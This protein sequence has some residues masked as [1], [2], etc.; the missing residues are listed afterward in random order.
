[1]NVKIGRRQ[2]EA[3]CYLFLGTVF[4]AIG[5]TLKA[6]EYNEKALAIATEI[7]DR[8]V[9]GMCYNQLEYIFENLG[10]CVIAEE[11]LKKAL[12]I[13]KNIGD[14]QIEFKC[15]CFLTLT[16]LTQKGLRK[17]SPIWNKAFENSRKLRRFL[18]DSDQFKISFADMNVFLY[19]ELS[20]LLFAAGNSKKAL[21]V[22]E[23]GWPRALADLMAIQY[24][25]Q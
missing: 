8:Q 25:A 18:G 7:G 11:C 12:S 23:Q 19:Q 21:S 22:A 2:G 16:K 14:G 5:N 6:K 4:E 24:S 1:M 3:A 9:E 15:Y 17:R 20:V 13:G 10:E